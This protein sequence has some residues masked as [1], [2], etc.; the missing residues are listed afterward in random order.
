MTSSHT[1]AR[2]QPVGLQHPRNAV[3]HAQQQ[4]IRLLVHAR[5]EKLAAPPHQPRHL[6][7]HL[8]VRAG[9]EGHTAP[10]AQQE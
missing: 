8:G 6:G 10:A 1:G 2:S 9:W 7:Q 4:R 5:V 3:V